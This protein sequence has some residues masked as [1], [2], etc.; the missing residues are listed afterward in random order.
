MVS[1]NKPEGLP[2]L[3]VPTITQP[4]EEAERWSFSQYEALA[5]QQNQTIL[6]S[7]ADAPVLPPRY[8]E[9]QISSH[10]LDADAIRAYRDNRPSQSIHV[11]EYEDRW[12]LHVDELNPKYD[13][14]GHLQRDAPFLFCL[15]LLGS[16][17]YL[18]DY[19][20]QP[21]SDSSAIFG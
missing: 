11:I 17:H 6:A 20:D 16:A 21:D 14:L 12:E 2:L 8:S 10:L 4:A 18:T 9:V 1:I 15:G 5:H 7:K 3:G 13:A 19:Q